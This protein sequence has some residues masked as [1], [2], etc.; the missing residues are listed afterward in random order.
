V[1]VLVSR[2]GR[3]SDREHRRRERLHETPADEFDPLRLRRTLGWA[4]VLM[5][6]GLLLATLLV[7]FYALPYR[8]ALGGSAA[9]EIAMSL[10]VGLMVV[11]TGALAWWGTKRSYGPRR[12]AGS[13][14]DGLS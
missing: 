14:R 12:R 13:T 2:A 3:V 4:G 7:V 6:F 10:G 5:L 9:G 8:R 1:V 11:L